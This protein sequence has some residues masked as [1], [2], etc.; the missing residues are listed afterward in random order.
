MPSFT[1]KWC[2]CD[3][4]CNHLPLN[5]NGLCSDCSESLTKKE[6]KMNR[7]NSLI[8]DINILWNTDINVACTDLCEISKRLN[9]T[10]YAY[11]NGVKIEPE[12]NSTPNELIKKYRTDN[13]NS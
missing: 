10:V 13:Q 3:V 6:S 11:F 9:F 8:L 12:P 7:L 1:C 5:F 4:M 2:G